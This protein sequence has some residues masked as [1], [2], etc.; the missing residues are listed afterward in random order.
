MKI[1]IPFAILIA[2]CS[3]NSVSQSSRHN[4]GTPELR[5]TD[6]QKIDI[7]FKIHKDVLQKMET[8][9]SIVEL[10]ELSLDARE[11]QKAAE[12]DLLSWDLTP[13]DQEKKLH[14]LQI[15][16]GEEIIKWA[17]TR[18]KI[19]CL[20]MGTINHANET[21]N[22][23]RESISSGDSDE[24]LIEK[25]SS[26]VQ[27][28]AECTGILPEIEYFNLNLQLKELA[29]SVDKAIKK[30]KLVSEHR[31]NIKIFLEETAK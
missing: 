12:R 20:A 3:T 16:R 19:Q 21:V 28:L 25:L 22:S 9:T 31:K 27:C 26:S 15:A 2:S 11:I 24:L 10:N 14:L 5:L 29:L 1:F 8:T 17:N 30:A 23:I 18:D 13:Q 6:L 7:W 4:S